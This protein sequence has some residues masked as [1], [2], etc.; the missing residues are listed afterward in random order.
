M[1]IVLFR[2]ATISG[3]GRNGA[4]RLPWGE[5][6]EVNDW[7]LTPVTVAVSGVLRLCTRQA[8]GSRGLSYSRENARLDMEMGHDTT[9]A[10]WH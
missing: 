1:P 2:G 7:R 3:V 10:M 8:G 4:G 5:V 9:L 6:E